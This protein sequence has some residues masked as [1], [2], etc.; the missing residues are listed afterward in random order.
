[1]PARLLQIVQFELDCRPYQ[2]GEAFS[3]NAPLGVLDFFMS[4]VGSVGL[5][6]EISL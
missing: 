2:G 5:E 6:R 1:M 4:L 3:I